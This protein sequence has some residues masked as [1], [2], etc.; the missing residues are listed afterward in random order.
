MCLEKLVKLISHMREK[1]IHANSGQMF[2]VQECVSYGFQPP[3]LRIPLRN[4]NSS[5]GSVVLM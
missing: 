5:S 3:T 2:T 4:N 1:S